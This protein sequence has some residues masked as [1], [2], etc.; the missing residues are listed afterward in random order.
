VRTGLLDDDWRNIDYILVTPVLKA[1]IDDGQLPAGAA[2]PRQRTAV[3]QVR[4]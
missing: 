1:A 3:R 4:A 2:G